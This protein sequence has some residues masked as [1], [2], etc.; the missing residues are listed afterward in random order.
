VKSRSIP[1]EASSIAHPPQG[2]DP[3]DAERIRD[4][5][6]QH[7]VV[8]QHR[9]QLVALEH[10]ARQR[11]ADLHRGRR[12]ARGALPAELQRLIDRL[13]DGQHL[14]L[15]ES[16][17]LGIARDLE[18]EIGG[19][20]QIGGGALREPGQFRGELIDL[21]LIGRDQAQAALQPLEL[22][23]GL[24]DVAKELSRR[25]DGEHAGEIFTG[26]RCRGAEA[27]DLAAHRRD[28]RAQ[29]LL[30]VGEI[31]RRHRPA[32]PQPLVRRLEPLDLALLLPDRRDIEH[33][34]RLAQPLGLGAHR[35]HGAGIGRFRLAQLGFELPGGELQCD[36]N[37]A[38]GHVSA[39]V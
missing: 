6:G 4:G 10:A 30:R 31:G 39:P 17:L 35:A 1:A 24:D 38:C 9:A 20:I 22:I 8:L 32:R 13:R 16:Q 37:G 14:L 7:P 25:G 19:R 5:L 11:L 34:E 33:A 27:G 12:G 29:G 28:L 2:A 3:V 21:L 26:R 15:A 18:I 36:F 23:G